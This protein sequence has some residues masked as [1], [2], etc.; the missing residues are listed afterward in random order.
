VFI[1]QH[2]VTDAAVHDSQE[3]EIVLDPDNADDGV[4]ADSA[5]DSAAI[6][7]VLALEGYESHIRGLQK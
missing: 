5:Y 3:L 2:S 4:W 6:D 7:R 1:R